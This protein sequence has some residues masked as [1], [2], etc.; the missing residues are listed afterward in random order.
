MSSTAYRS[1]LRKNLALAWPLAINV[2]LVQSMLMIDTVLVAP[3]GQIP[4]AAM[5]IATALVAFALGILLALGNGIQLLVGRAYG[6]KNSED[7]VIVFWVG[8]FLNSLT[9][10]SFFLILSAFGPALVAAITTDAEIGKQ[11]LSYLAI[12]KYIILF[13]AFTQVCTAFYNGCGNTWISLKGFLIEIPANITLSYVLIYGVGSFLGL[14]L[15]GAAW[16]SLVAVFLRAVYF[17]VCLH[18]DRSL[19][20]A[21]PRERA[22]IDELRPQSAEIFP[23]AVNFFVLFIGASVYQLLYAQLELSSFVAITLIFPW[24]RIGTQFVSAWAQAS[25]INISQALGRGE[26]LHLNAFIA[27]CTKTAI[28]LSVLVAL[29]FYVLSRFIH[30]VYPSVL[31]ETYTALAVIAPLYILLPV[32]RG[33]NALSGNVLRALGESKRVLKLNFTAQWLISLPV[34]ALLILYFDVSLFWAFAIMPI[35]ELLKIYHFN[36]YTKM[37]LNP[38]GGLH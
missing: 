1:D 11:V 20:L 34:C 21:Y 38:D 22:F 35:E 23:V 28:A 15:V 12:T 25:A 27:T 17:G 36:R 19:T 10:L 31:P 6:S 2:L 7:L 24:L 8:L 37:K 5:G 13:T 3:L 9:A 30:L 16:G 33:Y 32:L 4:V 29:M 26:I 14:G 18:L